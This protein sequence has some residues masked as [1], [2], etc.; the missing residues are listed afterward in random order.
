MRPALAEQPQSLRL[1]PAR[2]AQ[3]AQFQATLATLAPGEEQHWDGVCGSS[4]ALFAATLG[5]ERNAICVVVVAEE[6]KIERFH[7]DLEVFTDQRVESFPALDVA[8]G[9]SALMDDAYG[10][11]LR[12]LKQLCR[13]ERP[14][15]IVTSIQALQQ[16]LPRAAEVAE[17]TRLLRV[18]MSVSVDELSEWLV[19]HQ[20]HH[21]TAV[22]LPGEFSAARWHPRHLR[23]RLD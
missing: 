4:C 5:A 18:G 21:T 15:F 7:A 10:E 19:T 22:E 8:S 14:A 13:A 11:R 2:I 1:L 16:P 20:Y 23:H 17:Q 6:K 3:D 9:R 12:L